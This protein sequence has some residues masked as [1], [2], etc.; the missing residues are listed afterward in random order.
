MRYEGCLSLFDVRGQVHRPREVTIQAHDFEGKPWQGTYVDA[1]AR[2]ICHE[3]DHLD[4]LL[5]PD[6]MTK[7][8]ELVSVD[9]YRSLPDTDWTYT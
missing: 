6:R 7:P 3:L 4:G 2:L 5:Y 8:A 1:T 9:L